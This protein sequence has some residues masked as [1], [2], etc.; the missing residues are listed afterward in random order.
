MTEQDQGNGEI[1]EEMVQRLLKG[2]H[3]PPNGVAMADFI[4]VEFAHDP[5]TEAER[6]EAHRRY[7]D[8][9][10]EKGMSGLAEPE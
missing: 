3:D 5:P 9:L 7:V 1:R 10:A 8:E 6:E 2:Y 4:A